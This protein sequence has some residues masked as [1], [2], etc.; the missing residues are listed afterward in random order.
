VALTLSAEPLSIVPEFP[1]RSDVTACIILGCGQQGSAL[2]RGCRLTEGDQLVERRTCFPAGR[3][4][5][6]RRNELCPSEGESAIVSPTETMNINA[7]IGGLKRTENKRAGL[8]LTPR[9][10]SGRD[11]LHHPLSERNPSRLVWPHRLV[12]QIGLTRGSDRFLHV[13]KVRGF[14]SLDENHVAPKAETPVACNPTTKIKRSIEASI[15][16]RLGPR[17]IIGEGFS[18]GLR[19]EGIR[20][21][22]P[23]KQAFA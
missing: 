20:M 23:N 11:V 17:P 13:Q 19:I 1:K 4:E 6:S 16:L 3:S 18:L 21:T 7:I 8:R 5:V 14:L 22:F 9:Q 15:R 12:G 10:V 2:N